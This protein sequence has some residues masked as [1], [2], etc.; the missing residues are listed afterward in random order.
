MFKS[1][2]SI[3][4]YDIKYFIHPSALMHGHLRLRCAY[5]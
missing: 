1:T 5:K 4:N 2:E 3:V